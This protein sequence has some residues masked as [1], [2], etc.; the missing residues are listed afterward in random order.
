MDNYEFMSALS[1]G[2]KLFMAA[3]I[4]FDVNN[5]TQFLNEF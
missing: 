2:M 4:Y 1:R 5:D 3:L